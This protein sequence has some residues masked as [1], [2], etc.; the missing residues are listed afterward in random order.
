MHARRFACMLLGMWLGCSG[1]MTWVTLESFKPAPHVIEARDPHLNGRQPATAPESVQKVLAY[2]VRQQVGSWLEGWGSGEIAIG[3]FFFF[4][5]LFGT[6]EGKLTLGL[7]LIPLAAAAVQRVLITPQ[8]IYL[9]GKSEVAPELGP[10]RVGFI[11]V[12][13]IVLCSGAILAA[14]LIGR[15]HGRE[16]L[17]LEQVGAIRK[18]G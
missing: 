7:S 1:L 9:G 18:R 12:E 6:R 3:A 8:L 14:L 5:L 2:G 10:V 15:Q 16:G 11:L 13:A 4:Y 17:T